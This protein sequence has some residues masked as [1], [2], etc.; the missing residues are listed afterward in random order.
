MPRHLQP[1]SG[2]APELNIHSLGFFAGSGRSTN[3][4]A[5]P[6]Q[7]SGSRHAMLSPGRNRRLMTLHWRDIVFKAR[8]CL[9][10]P[11]IFWPNPVPTSPEGRVAQLAEQLT[12]NQ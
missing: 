6:G 9:A 7:I 3:R 11:A 10:N 2:S 12:L 4:I 5:E 1:S 8:L